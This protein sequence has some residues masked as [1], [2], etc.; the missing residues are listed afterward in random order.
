MLILLLRHKPR[1][2]YVRAFV[3]L[4]V[5]RGQ[6][7]LPTTRSGSIRTVVTRWATR[8]RQDVGHLFD[9][10]T[11]LETT[12]ASSTCCQKT[13]IVAGCLLLKDI[14][15]PL[16]TSLSTVNLALENQPAAIRV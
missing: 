3:A 7:Q 5:V 11:C 1:T 4:R 15:H 14:D 8:F 2:R 9:F 12:T 13:A 6:C 10:N 16:L